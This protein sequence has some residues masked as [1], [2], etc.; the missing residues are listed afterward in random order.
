MP[1]HPGHPAATHV[2]R[3]RAHL[4]SARR[5]RP[6]ARKGAVAVALATA[7]VAAL[8]AAILR[9][10]TSEAAAT[11]PAVQAAVPASDVTWSPGDDISWEYLPEKNQCITTQSGTV[12]TSTPDQATQ[13][14][15]A[16]QQAGPKTDFAPETGI[17]DAH[18][19]VSNT[20][21]GPETGST[22]VN[23]VIHSYVTKEKC[24]AATTPDPGATP[25]STSPAV[26][27][28]LRADSTQTWTFSGVAALFAAVT[29]AAFTFLAA[30]SITTAA[31]IAG[32]TVSAGVVAVAA[33]CI[34]GAAAGALSNLLIQYNTQPA[35]ND[36]KSAL[37]SAVTGCIGGGFISAIPAKEAAA[38]VAGF[39]NDTVGGSAS[40][41]VGTAG[42][43]AAASTG[44]ELATITE[45]VSTATTA[46]RTVR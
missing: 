11:T 40:A 9:P 42:A 10:S 15:E 13:L 20:A 25:G 14:I 17:L 38:S 18:V 7:L 8:T 4:S 23:M 24:E 43:G 31:T 33:G 21:N 1:D 27:G 29:Y 45:V 36:W 22:T 37:A 34:G 32:V 46:L 2:P 35:T 28:K 19:N 6:L 16:L 5:L 30:T 41:L 39:L 26:S 12:T 44:I 3:N